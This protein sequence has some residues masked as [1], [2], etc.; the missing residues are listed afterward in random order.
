MIIP[1]A[2]ESLNFSCANNA[3]E[4]TCKS[5]KSEGL[6]NLEG[7]SVGDAEAMGWLH[8]WQDVGFSHL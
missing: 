5:A 7:G 1:V 8:H 6:K 3:P 2:K 4:I